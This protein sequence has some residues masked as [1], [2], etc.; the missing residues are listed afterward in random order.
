MD[1]QI[2]YAVLDDRLKVLRQYAYQD[3]VTLI[4]RPDT[5]T[6]IGEDGKTYQ[7]ETQVF[8][9]RKKGGDVRVIVA[10]DDGGWRA[11]KPLSDSF[12]MARDGTFVCEANL[13]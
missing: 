6:A 11:F 2:A 3:L 8:W 9:D 10:V 1:H 4:G 7:L 12:I 5:N 13:F